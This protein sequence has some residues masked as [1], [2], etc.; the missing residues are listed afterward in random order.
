MIVDVNYMKRRLEERN[1]KAQ[2][3]DDLSKDRLNLLRE[4]DEV[5][6]VGRA[7]TITLS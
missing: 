5:K 4:E 3:N 6:M 1:K 2:E 7:Q